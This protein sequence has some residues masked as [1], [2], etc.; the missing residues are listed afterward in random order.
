MSN[1]VMYFDTFKKSKINS[2]QFIFFSN[3]ENT[4]HAI[5]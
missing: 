2:I 4:A 5:P 3:N 1:Y